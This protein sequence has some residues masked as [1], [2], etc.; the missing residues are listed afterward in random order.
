MDYEHIVHATDALKTR[1][2]WYSRYIIV[3]EEPADP[4]TYGSYVPELYCYS[5]YR[6]DDVQELFRQG[7][8]IPVAQ[9]FN[10]ICDSLS[11]YHQRNDYGWWADCFMWMMCDPY[12]PYR[13]PTTGWTDFLAFVAHEHALEMLYDTFTDD[14]EYPL[15]MDI[16]HFIGRLFADMYQTNLKIAFERNKKKMPSTRLCCSLKIGQRMSSATTLGRYSPSVILLYYA[17]CFLI[18]HCLPI[19]FFVLSTLIPCF[20][21]NCT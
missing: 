8:A 14:R 12:H 13:S 21:A 3:F 15:W 6:Y 10:G 11:C 4:G 7:K 18:T 16:A 20:L 1:H 2:G 9:R 17:P 19:S 5:Q